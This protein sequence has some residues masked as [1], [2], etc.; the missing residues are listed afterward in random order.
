MNKLTTCPGSADKYRLPS[1][2]Q[3]ET[4]TD[5]KKFRQPRHKGLQAVLGGYTLWTS[6]QNE[7]KKK[8]DQ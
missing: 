5:T 3:H 6:L 2:S 1:R 4:Y 8:K 7:G